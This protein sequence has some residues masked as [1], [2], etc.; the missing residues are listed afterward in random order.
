MGTI[1]VEGYSPELGDIVVTV[2]DRQLAQQAAENAATAA[3]EVAAE[4]VEVERFK[5]EVVIASVASEKSAAAAEAA[6]KAAQQA[7]G[8]AAAPTDV[9]VSQ[10]LPNPETLSGKAAAAVVVRELTPSPNPEVP[11]PAAYM[12]VAELVDEKLALF[13][14]AE[15]RRPY[16][17]GSNL[18]AP[19][20]AGYDGFLEW[21][22][23]A[24]EGSVPVFARDGDDVLYIVVETAPWTPLLAPGIANMWHSPWAGLA[25]GDRAAIADAG[26]EGHH[27]APLGTSHPTFQIAGLNGHPA[28]LYD[29]V[30]DQLKATGFDGYAGPTT[31]YLVAQSL[32]ASVSGTRYFFDGLNGAT[33]QQLAIS[34]TPSTFNAHK[35]SALVGP[36]GNAALH[37]FR[38]IYNGASSS[39]RV[40]S[41]APVT[42]S[43]SVSTGLTDMVI[44]GPGDSAAGNMHNCMVGSLLR[45]KGVVDDGNDAMIMTWLRE[46]FGL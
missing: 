29:G 45:F 20:P 15:Y 17:I 39:L 33:R 8:E 7:A 25:N 32:P 21:R 34:R 4:R 13:S 31:V 27:M 41:A 5:S 1:R 16:F 36:A 24:A 28:V 26:P 30:D 18:T 40:D 11:D 23:T 22:T 2:E 10:L 19:R 38:A 9:M 14:P 44:G 46:E 35:G 3:R 6:R 37:I 12:A 42:G 43:T